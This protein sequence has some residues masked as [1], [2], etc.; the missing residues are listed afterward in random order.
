MEVLMD[1]YEKLDEHYQILGST[2]FIIS[3][4]LAKATGNV[5]PRENGFEMAPSLIEA[6]GGKEKAGPLYLKLQTKISSRSRWLPL[7]DSFIET[8]K[9]S[10]AQTRKRKGRSD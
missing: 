3:L 8:Y 5:T 2:M 4:E 1:N 9:E 7:N 6:L 10:L